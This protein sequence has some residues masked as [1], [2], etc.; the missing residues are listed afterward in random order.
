MP[1]IKHNFT[2]GKMNKDL[3]ERL[4]PNGEYR[5]AMNIQVSTSEG[6]EVG[7]IQNILGNNKV[8]SQDFI[9]EGDR[10]VSSVADE[11]NDKLYWFITN[12]FPWNGIYASITS[13]P[14]GKI[15]RDAIIEYDNS[16]NSITPVFIDFWLIEFPWPKQLTFGYITQFQLNNTNGISVGM[17]VQLVYAAMTDERTITNIN[18][19]NNTITVDSSFYASSYLN[20]VRF[21]NPGVTTTIGPYMLGTTTVP[22]VE[23]T[24]IRR[25]LNFDINRPITGVNIIDDFLLWTDDCYEPKKINIQRSKDGTNPNGLE[26]T[27]LVIP[28]NNISITD[29][30]HSREDHITVIRKSPK[31]PLSIEY[32]TGRDDNL[33]YTGVIEITDQLVSTSIAQGSLMGSSKGPIN[34]FSSLVVGDW[35]RIFVPEDINGNANPILEWNVGTKVVL[36]E[37][38]DNGNAPTVPIKYYTIKGFVAEISPYLTSSGASQFRIQIQSIS[39]F[40]PVVPTGNTEL[41]YVI[42]L[43]DETEKIF[44][45]KFPRFAYRY[46]YEDGEYSAFS[47]FTEVAFEPGSFDYH[48]SK[49]YNLGMTNNLVS[50]KI[51]NFITSDMPKDVVAIDLLYKEENSPNIYL[52]DTIKHESTT[53]DKYWEDNEYEITSDTIKSSTLASNQLLRPWDNVPRKALSQEIIGNRIIY[54]NY[55]QNYDLNTDNFDNY[56]PVFEHNLNAFFPSPSDPIKSIKSLREYQLGVV[57][58]DEYGRE[59]PVLSNNTGTFR[60]NKD[61]SKVS[62]SIEVGMKGVEFPKTMKYFKFFIKETSGEY[63]NLAMGRWYDAA[64]G[65]IW[66]AF[67]ST[68]RNKVDIDTFLILKKGQDSD[69]GIDEAGRYNIIAIENEAPDHIKTSKMLIEE[70]TNTGGQLFGATG[71]ATY[72]IGFE[73][74]TG[75]DKFQMKYDPFDNSSGGALDEITDELYVEFTIENTNRVSDRYKVSTIVNTDPGGSAADYVVAIDGKFQDDVDFISNTGDANGTSIHEEAQ[76]RFYRYKVE[77][78]PEFDGRFFVKI[79]N[80]NLFKSEIINAGNTAK[81]YN[82]ISSRKVYYMKGELLSSHVDFNSDDETAEWRTAAASGFST[83]NSDYEHYRANYFYYFNNSDGPWD[84]TAKDKWNDYWFIDASGSQ[85]KLPT[86]KN[87]YST[88]GDLGTQSWNDVKPYERGGNQNYGVNKSSIK[89]ANNPYN[90]KES[91]IGIQHDPSNNEWSKMDLSFGGIKGSWKNDKEV[92]GN[93]V[94]HVIG[95]SVWK[96][97]IWTLKSGASSF[98]DI[99]SLGGNTYHEDQR[100]FVE[101]IAPATLIR[102]KDDPNIDNVYRMKSGIEYKQKAKHT[103]DYRFKNNNAA[104]IKSPVG[105]GHKKYYNPNNGNGEGTPYKSRDNWVKS[106]TTTVEP[107][108]LWDPTA[109]DSDGSIVNGEVINVTVA[110]VNTTSAG[111]P[112]QYILQIDTLT[113]TSSFTNDD[114]DIQI[115]MALQKYTVSG[116][117]VST[118]TEV[119]VVTD[120]VKSGSNYWI[121]LGGWSGPITTSTAPTGTLVAGVYTF[122]QPAMNGF[123]GASADVYTRMTGSISSGT[124]AAVGYELEIVQPAEPDNKLPANPAIFETE[125]KEITELDLYY[126]ISGYNPIILDHSTI[127]TVIPIGSTVS[128]VPLPT[129]S[130]NVPVGSSILPSTTEILDVINGNEI[131]LSCTFTGTQAFT[132]V[133]SGNLVN[134]TATYHVDLGDTLKVK[135]ADGSTVE[136]VVIGF[137]NLLGNTGKGGASWPVYNKIFIDTFLYNSKYTLNWHNCYSFGNGVESNRIRDNFNLQYV[138]NGVKASTVLEDVEYKEERRKYGLIY[139]GLYNSISGVNNL[140]QFIQAEKITKDINPIYGSIQKL[141]ARDTDLVTLCEDK[142]LRILANKDAVYEA[143]GNSQLTAT[144]RVLGQAI[145][146][147]GEFGISKNPESFASEAYRSYFTDKQRGAVM[148]LSKDGLTPISMHGMKDWFRDN[149]KLSNKLI[150]SYDDRNDEYNITLKDISKTVSFKEDVRGWVSFKSFI[151]ENAISCANNYFTILNGI[152]YKHYNENVDR[153]TFYDE[154]TD[155]SF[156]VVLNDSPG[157]VK[158]FHTLDYEGSQSQIIPTVFYDASGVSMLE[159]QYYNLT[160]KDGWY[161][162][163]ITTDLESGSLNEFIEKEGK[164]FNYLRGKSITTYSNEF[165]KSNYDTDSFA[166]QGVGFANSIDCPECASD[167]FWDCIQIS[168]TECECQV[169]NYQTTYTTKDTC[170]SEDNCCDPIIPFISISGCMDPTAV[171]YNPLANVDDG[172]CEYEVTAPIIYGCTNPSA[173][174]YNPLATVNDGTCNFEIPISDEP[175]TELTAGDPKILEERETKVVGEY[176]NGCTDPIATNYNPLATRDDGS[177]IYSNTVCTTPTVTIHTI[178]STSAIATWN[179]YATAHAHQ[180]ELMNPTTNEI[181]TSASIPAA[182]L[183]HSIPFLVLSPNTSYNFNL[184]T[185]CVGGLI[186][187]TTTTTFTTT[188]E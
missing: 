91:S 168:G 41:K 188:K 1:E 62:N 108:F 7:T 164:W 107:R 23:R 99:G 93:K 111:N 183:G 88:W 66:I 160:Q 166:I 55:V 100:D 74:K 81:E 33:T 44:E 173:L 76:V 36:K 177:C 185:Y 83:Y 19:S 152:L 25:V 167:P 73:P 82:T 43:F 174:N 133:S 144:S 136:V 101:N 151:P 29:N 127:H 171:N 72:S 89:V 126:E 131:E 86:N 27:K 110:T 35:F 4:I 38:D 94:E 140:N 124:V 184:T 172:N 125:P 49:G 22:A 54:G 143:D 180:Y 153:N 112:Y 21:V 79:Y 37:Y 135:R 3:D 122:V 170:E 14:D 98:F 159:D 103:I 57:F 147:V 158:S 155:S 149:L 68:D 116:P 175:I 146:F 42:D 15:Y 70:K 45:F 75:G 53:E 132:P 95:S 60:T 11:K 96:Y 92:R 30:I 178:T 186:G 84:S 128:H 148:R 46:K 123:T 2:K 182:S 50:L 47:P 102:W 109:A 142:I 129:S 32:D 6:A 48:I 26:H 154:Y 28:K 169:V 17:K 176:V 77:N 150:G 113:G 138:L 80:D 65:N 56:T 117:T 8:L 130:S 12:E 179:S 87:S 13:N 163:N 71:T 97:Y 34:N 9:V 61:D 20:A 5:D 121:F 69:S 139:S 39:D 10:C 157:S 120:I 40:P 115:G 118:L 181:V 78:K 16:S 85:G 141:H 52:V 134:Q 105:M 67:P 161:V 58:I 63:Y 114:K 162:A 51:K 104:L 156:D 187:S 165:V 64:D 106:Y 59:T 137:G 31:S 90:N 145:P 119:L 18:T 24:E